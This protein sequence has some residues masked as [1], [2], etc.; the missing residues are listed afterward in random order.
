[1]KRIYKYPLADSEAQ[2][3]LLPL[4]AK[5]LSLQVQKGIPCLWV[6]SNFPCSTY[7]PVT[8]ITYGTG[9]GMADRLD[10]YIGTYQLYDGDLVFHVYRRCA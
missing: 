8:F 4:G 7:V 2:E 10:E 5:I 6:E 3:I 1:M 9:H